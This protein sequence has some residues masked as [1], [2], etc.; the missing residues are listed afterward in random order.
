M[1]NL[2]LIFFFCIGSWAQAQ[3]D[4]N[5]FSSA[6]RN[7]EATQSEKPAFETANAGGPGNPGGGSQDDDPVPIDDYIPLLVVTALGIILYTSH[8][9]R[10][11]LA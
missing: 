5:P 7:N 2:L 6:E 10:N 8:K 9:K 1:K 3:D 11:R 4:N